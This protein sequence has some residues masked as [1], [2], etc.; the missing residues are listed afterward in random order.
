MPAFDAQ[1]F[2]RTTGIARRVVEYERGE[3]IF[4]QG[5]TC[6]H[7]LYIQRGGV[8]LSVKS[9]TGREAV[10]AMLGPADFFGEACLAGQR[11]RTG[12]A[13]AIT[14]SAILLVDKRRMVRLLH[15]QRAMSDRFIA[16]MLARS[17]SIEQDLID[18]VLNPIETRLARTLLRLARYGQQDKPQRVIPKIPQDTLAE[19]VGTTRSRVKFFLNKFKKLGFIQGNGKLTINR[20]L[21]SVMLRE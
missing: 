18:Q 4:S 14:P 15:R 17:I 1:A 20:S 21:L 7:V 11:F 3:T 2:L 12:S 19:M 8:K 16:H 13:T 5:D 6:E 10:V 9:K